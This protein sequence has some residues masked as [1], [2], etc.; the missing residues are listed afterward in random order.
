MMEEERKKID[1]ILLTPSQQPSPRP[2][3][4]MSYECRQALLAEIDDLIDE[5]ATRAEAYEKLDQLFS[6]YNAGF[7]FL[8]GPAY[9]LAIDDLFKYVKMEWDARNKRLREEGKGK[10]AEVFEKQWS[11][12]QIRQWV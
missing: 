12:E 8:Q 9:D 11:D 2:L 3:K 6:T 7:D 5:E 4:R 10:L 1:V